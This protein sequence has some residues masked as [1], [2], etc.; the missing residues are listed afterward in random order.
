MQHGTHYGHSRSMSGGGQFVARLMI[1]DLK[2]SDGG[3]EHLMN[4]RNEVGNTN[5]TVRIQDI[6][7]KIIIFS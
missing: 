1:E 6:K 2:V 4:V 5:Y 7:S 3:V